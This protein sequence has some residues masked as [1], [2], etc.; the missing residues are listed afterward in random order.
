MREAAKEKMGFYAADVRALSV[1][2]ARIVP[3]TDKSNR[4]IADF[5]A[6]EGEAIQHI[7]KYL[8]LSEARVYAVELDRERSKAIAERMPDANLLGGT[9]FFGA[10]VWARCYSL[11]YLNSPF[12]A[13]PSFGRIEIQW[14]YAVTNTLV[15]DG[16]LFMVCPQAV[17]ESLK[18]EKVL[19]M[20]YKNVSIIKFPEAYRTGS[21]YEV[22]ILA[23]RLEWPR[24]LDEIDEMKYGANNAKP[25]FTYQVP[26]ARGPSKFEKTELTELEI[27]EHVA[28][29]PL[30][31]RLQT[32]VVA[33]IKRPPL[34]LQT[35]HLAL[36]LSC[37]QLDGTVYPKDGSESHVIRGTARKRDIEKEVI[38]TSESTTTV[39]SEQIQMIIRKVD[40]SGVIKTLS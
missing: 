27:E 30:L 10:E 32:P 7:A 22:M 35:G 28:G 3:P 20:F 25:G 38:E 26:A 40:K 5:C 34:A 2:L 14:L 15:D 17:A 9:S 13:H 29:S 18:T 24:S 21:G 1:G 39:I 16:L 8:G 23:Q 11:C 31:T 36:L 37:G 33:P 4:F 6:G 19:S 12:G